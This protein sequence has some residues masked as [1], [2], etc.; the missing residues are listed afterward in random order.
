MPTKKKKNQKET[1]FPESQVMTMFESMND[2]IEILAE[3]Q[4]QLIQNQNGLKDDL[5][6]FKV[7]IK[8]DLLDFKIETRDNFK[9]V[10]QKLDK[11]EK[12]LQNHDQEFEKINK[13]LKNH[14]KKFEQI[15]KRFEQVDE[16][17]TKVFNSLDEIKQ[18]VRDIRKELDQMKEQPVIKREEFEILVKRMERVEMSMDR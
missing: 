14:D 7:E 18:E 11:H 4:K 17:F 8:G 1:A 15:D 3:S 6:N 16:N 12:H 13:T 10:N 2:G 5:E 9:K